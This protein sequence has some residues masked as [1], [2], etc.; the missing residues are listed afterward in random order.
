[1]ERF[2]LSLSTLDVILIFYRLLS[3]TRVSAGYSVD[4]TPPPFLPDAEDLRLPHVG[5]DPWSYP[6]IPSR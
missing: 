4:P 3:G 2:P 6:E 1:M 5:H